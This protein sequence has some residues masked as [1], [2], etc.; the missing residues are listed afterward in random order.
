MN[1]R[2]FALIIIVLTSM[3]FIS[4]CAQTTS[5]KSQEEVGQVVTNVSTDIEGVSSTLDSIDRTLGGG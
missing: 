3:V 4:G 2:A 1:K 5:I